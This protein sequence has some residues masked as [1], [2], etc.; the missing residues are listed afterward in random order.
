MA[1]LNC[2]SN[3][4]SK[5]SLE[6]E[7]W[8]NLCVFEVVLIKSKHTHTHT[9]AGERWQTLACSPLHQL[10]SRQQR[11]VA[12][13]AWQTHKSPLCSSL[14]PNLQLL[15]TGLISRSEAQEAVCVCVLH[16][17]FVHSDI[18]LCLNPFVL[19]ANPMEK[20]KQAMILSLWAWSSNAWV[21][22]K[23]HVVQKWTKEKSCSFESSF[24]A[25]CFK[26]WLVNP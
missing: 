7:L 9:L 8:M 2:S 23:L 3:T 16:L 18:I 17:C 26:E 15:T 21:A 20:I 12:A 25:V 24:N 5:L 19:S 1:K 22:Y 10:V 14:M 13:H 11:Y 4:S 6:K